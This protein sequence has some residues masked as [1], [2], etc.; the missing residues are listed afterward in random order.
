MGVYDYNR[1]TK[2]ERAARRQRA[3]DITSG[4]RGS[5]GLTAAERQLLDELRRQGLAIRRGW[6][7]DERRA[8]AW[9]HGRIVE[10]A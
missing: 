1:E 6:L 10:V 7:I 8:Q 4:T 9:Q 5:D 3:Q 2:A